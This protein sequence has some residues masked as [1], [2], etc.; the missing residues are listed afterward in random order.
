M[1]R[2]DLDTFQIEDFERRMKFGIFQGMKE[3]TEMPI[4]ALSQDD[5]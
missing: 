3:A 4:F 1:Q 2:A 5:G